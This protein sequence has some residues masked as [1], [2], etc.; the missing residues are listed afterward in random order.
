M[1]ENK[2]E[3]NKVVNRWLRSKAR[4]NASRLRFLVD[5]LSA[6]SVKESRIL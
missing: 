1:R 6:L 2:V 4:I 3:I 5:A